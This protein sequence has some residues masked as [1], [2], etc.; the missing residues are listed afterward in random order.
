MIANF[1]DHVLPKLQNESKVCVMLGTM[2]ERVDEDGEEVNVKYFRPDFNSNVCLLHIVS[3]A[4]AVDVLKK[5]LDEGNIK[6]DLGIQRPDSKYKLCFYTNMQF[7]VFSGVD[8][9]IG[10]RSACQL[11]HL[12]ALPEMFKSN[13]RRYIWTPKERGDKLCLFRCLD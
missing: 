9:L 11:P 2:M 1:K 5:D 13:R 8:A 4:S 7:K 10:G 3:K 12:P 6:A